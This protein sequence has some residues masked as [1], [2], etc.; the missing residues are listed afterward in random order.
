M[1]SEVVAV[2]A[3]LALPWLT[4]ARPRSGEV[5]VGVAAGLGVTGAALVQP[6]GLAT[7][8][9]WTMA[10]SLFLPPILYG[11]AVTSILVTGLALRRQPGGGELAAG[12]ALVWL[13]GLKL[14]VS[15]YALMALAGLV[16]ASR[17]AETLAIGAEVSV[18][19]PSRLS[20]AGL[21]RPIS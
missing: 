5:L 9:I 15:S 18:A 1:L 20:V 10:F 13:A 17:A 3:A 19:S 14:D 7:V 16:I 21:R 8:A 11:A 12:L 4:R 2:V 6:W